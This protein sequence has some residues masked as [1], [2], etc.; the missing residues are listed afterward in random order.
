[1]IS[2]IILQTCTSEENKYK[3]TNVTT[4]MRVVFFFGFDAQ[5]RPARGR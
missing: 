2:K 5:N 3:N 1:M 4:A